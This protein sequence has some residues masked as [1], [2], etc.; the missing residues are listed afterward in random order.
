[1]FGVF[2]RGHVERFADAVLDQHIRTYQ[3]MRVHIRDDPPVVDHDHPVN[4][5][6]QHVL[7]PVFNDEDGLCICL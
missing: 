3:L 6:V 5:A 2:H 7:Q 4:L 1:M